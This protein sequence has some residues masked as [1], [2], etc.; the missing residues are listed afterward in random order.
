MR[1]CHNCP[2]V[3]LHVDIMYSACQEFSRCGSKWLN[4]W[5]VHTLTKNGIYFEKNPTNS[6]AKMSTICFKVV[7]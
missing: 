4:K 3:C 6:A 7:M 1:E 2:Q 5:K